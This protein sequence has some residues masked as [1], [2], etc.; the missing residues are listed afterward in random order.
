LDVFSNR[1]YEH[2]ILNEMEKDVSGDTTDTCTDVQSA[3]S[4]GS[5]S[6]GSWFER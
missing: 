4:T 3:E 1:F 2:D 5:F 6:Y